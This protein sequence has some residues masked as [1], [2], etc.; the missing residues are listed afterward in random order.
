MANADATLQTV[1]ACDHKGEVRTWAL[2]YDGRYEVAGD[3][4]DVT[5]DPVGG[6]QTWTA[7]VMRG[8]RVVYRLT[9]AEVRALVGCYELRDCRG[10]R[11]L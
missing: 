10:K 7:A 4:I 9:A 8:S 5:Y 1:W 3:Q 2:P 11:Y 6:A